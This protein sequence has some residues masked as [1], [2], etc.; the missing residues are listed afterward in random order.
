MSGGHWNY[1]GFTIQDRL[2]E[3]AYDENVL[4]RWPLVAESFRRLADTI[5]DVEHAMD[6]D[7]SGDSSIEDDAAFDKQSARLLRAA[8]DDYGA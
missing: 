6:W 4:K 2:Q 5:Y 7:I 1:A 8:I 3:I